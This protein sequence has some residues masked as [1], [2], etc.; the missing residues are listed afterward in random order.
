MG[1][2][3]K[4]PTPRKAAAPKPAPKVGKKARIARA[5]A[6]WREARQIAEGEPEGSDLAAVLADTAAVR[7]DEYET[8]CDEYGVCRVSGCYR[9]AAQQVRRCV[10]HQPR[11]IGA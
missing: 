4:T 11:G 6:D 1:S 5:Q 8:L 3:H 10:A 7:R 9:P 2:R